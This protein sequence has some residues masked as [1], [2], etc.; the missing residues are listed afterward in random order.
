MN[1][2]AR[3]EEV[4]QARYYLELSIILKLSI[5]VEFLLCKVLLFI[6]SYIIVMGYVKFYI[7]LNLIL[8]FFLAM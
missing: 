6:F 3:D 8:N 7:F 4:I 5:T 1:W 2:V